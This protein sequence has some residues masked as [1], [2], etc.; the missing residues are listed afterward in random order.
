MH[1]LPKKFMGPDGIPCVLAV[2]EDGNTEVGYI[3]RQYSLYH[4]LVTNGSTYTAPAFLVQNAE[5]IADL[6]N[7]PPRTFTILLA[8]PTG[9]GDAQNISHF[10]GNRCKTV[11]GHGYKW[12]LQSP[13][14]T[15]AGITAPDL[16]GD[17]LRLLEDG[18]F[19][20]LED[21]SFW[22]LETHNGPFIL[23]EDDNYFLLE[24]G[25]RFELEGV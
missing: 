24:D 2:D 12:H 6:S 19:W 9:G 14:D 11:Q 3:K 22:E 21:G 18:S 10:I 20:L 23:L 16:G 7:I 15:V 13:T 1:P 17:N 5:D 8:P 4:F 25:N